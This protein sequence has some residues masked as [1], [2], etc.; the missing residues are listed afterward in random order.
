MEL[1]EPL[2]LTC[3]LFDWARSNWRCGMGMGHCK[4]AAA[5]RYT[6][7]LHDRSLT[8]M[9]MT[10]GTSTKPGWNS[11][12]CL[13]CYECA[14]GCLVSLR[15]CDDVQRSRLTWILLTVVFNVAKSALNTIQDARLHDPIHT[16]RDRR[17]HWP[18]SAISDPGARR[19][20]ERRFR[21]PHSKGKLGCLACVQL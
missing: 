6:G 19:F 1:L 18:Q 10:T 3:R 14:Q 13:L 9:K 21:Q 20:E 4:P 7:Y 8:R 5:L 16:C 17:A 11:R 12:L 15:Y 2:D